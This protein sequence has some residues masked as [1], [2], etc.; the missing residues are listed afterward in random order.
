MAQATIENFQHGNV[1]FAV[2]TNVNSPHLTSP[3]MSLSGLP[4]PSSRKQVSGSNLT[5]FT[6]AD[7]QLSEIAQKF[8]IPAIMTKPVLSR[9]EEELGE[10][11]QSNRT[12]AYKLSNTQ[13]MFPSSP[14]SAQHLNLDLNHTLDLPSDIDSR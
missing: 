3:S 12:S 11:L 7:N 1:V 6:D 14:Q 2:A 5:S 13:M 9:D 10:L 8:I 4:E